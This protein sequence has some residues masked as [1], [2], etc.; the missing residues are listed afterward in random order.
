M[1]VRKL[2][3]IKFDG[4]TWVIDERL[5]QARHITQT[6]GFKFVPFDSE[7]GIK[8]LK[9]YKAQRDKKIKGFDR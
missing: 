1:K 6:G 8:I 2:P 4:L 3:Q 7:E 9:A 5:E